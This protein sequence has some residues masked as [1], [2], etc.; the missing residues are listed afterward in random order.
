M[1]AICY[2]YHL[3]SECAFCKSALRIILVFSL[4]TNQSYAFEVPLHILKKF[5]NSQT[6][7]L[8]VE[9][10]DKTIEKT[11][12]IMRNKKVRAIDDNEILRFK[13]K[14]YKAL[15]DKVDNQHIGNDISD[16]KNYSDLPIKYK[17]FKSENALK[18]YLATAGVKAIYENKLLQRVLTESLP[19][20]NQPNLSLPSARGAGTTVAVLDDGID[21]MHSAF[22]NCTSPNVPASSCKV[23]VYREFSNIPSTSN[24]HGT[25]VSAIVL[26]VAPATKIAMLNVFSTEG[27]FVSDII[28]A[29]NWSISNKA[30]YNIE[31]MN[32]SLGDNSRNASYCNS[33]WFTAPF[34]N[35]RNAG[36]SIVVASGNS[37]F[38]DGIA[39]PA[40][41][42]EAISVGAVYDAVVGGFSYGVCTDTTSNADQVTCFSNSANI[43]T[44]LAPGGE[45]TAASIT[46]FGTS[47][48]APHVAGAVA[49]L[50][51][52][53]PNENL[54]QIQSR[55]IN[56]GIPVLDIRNNITKPRLNLLAAGRPVNDAFANRISLIGASGNTSGQSTLASKETNEPNHASNIGG[57]SVWWKWVAT[58]NGQLS[59]TTSGSAFDTI[60]AVYEGADI[61]A[62]L[63]VAF[64]DNEL[65]SGTSSSIFLNA[66]AGR[67]YQIALDGAN[68]SSGEINLAWALNTTPAANLSLSLTGSNS[69]QLGQS[70]NYNIIINNLGPQA[71]TN[72]RV[73]I[74]IPSGASLVTSPNG[75]NLSANVLTC[76]APFILNGGIQVF[77]IQLIWNTLTTPVVLSATAS[78]E[79]A[80]TVSANNTSSLQVNLNTNSGGGSNPGE[81]QDGDVPT[82]PEWATIFLILILFWQ[83][84]KVRNLP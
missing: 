44:M 42:P 16:L 65:A 72:A 63:P 6:V 32:L 10:D 47:Q 62:L 68:G 14:E 11:A 74:T 50:R 60:L 12:K 49:V 70:V 22:G 76:L 73:V 5:N 27:A 43:L 29:I 23:V 54:N 31:A 41:A 46:Q 24:A 66:V 64:N 7:D 77:N 3:F 21:Y 81:S 1:L 45:I 57:Y 39:A 48:A 26:G 55:L 67:E 79:L 25:N 38:S 15:K 52:L 18:K 13:R 51:A 71:A 35:A 59:L 61:S 20:I 84:F 69:V 9:Y 17:R 4:L 2:C 19:L 30:T 82:L 78:S 28:D 8:V 37:A 40:C 53:Y 58:A 33:D 34:Q 80:D 36:I 56:S 75:C 83:N